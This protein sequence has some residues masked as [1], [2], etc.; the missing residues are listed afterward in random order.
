MIDFQKRN[1][2]LEQENKELREEIAGLRNT[3]LKSTSNYEDQL[4][5]GKRY[6]ESQV[7]FRTIFEQSKLGNK[8]ISPDLKIRKVNKALEEMLGYSEEELIHKKILDFAHP[9]S[10][11]NWLELQKKLWR[12]EMPSFHIEANMLR[13]DGT[14]IWCSVTT[15]LFEDN[16]SKLGYTILEDISER[17]ILSTKLANSESMLAQS[18]QAASI[19]SFVAD[20]QTGMVECT[21]GLNQMF[22]FPEGERFIHKD[23]FFRTIDA[24]TLEKH[25]QILARA[26]E[27][28]GSYTSE[29]KIKVAGLEKWVWE[30]GQVRKDDSGDVTIVG[31]VQANNS[32][33]L[34]LLHKIINGSTNTVTVGQAVRNEMGNIVDFRYI[35]F[36]N[37]AKRYMGAPEDSDE[38]IGKTLTELFPA[39]RHNGNLER[40]IETLENNRS[41]KGLEYLYPHE[42]LNHWFSESAYCFGECIV[43]SLDDITDRK[44][45]EEALKKLAVRNDELDSFVYT[46]SHDLRSPATNIEML[47]EYFFK[48]SQVS[49]EN[50]KS[51]LY[52]NL[53]NQSLTTLKNTLEDLTTVTEI[54]PGEKKELVNLKTVVADVEIM[55]AN[56]IQEAAA[57]VIVDLSVPFLNIPSKHARSLIFNMLSN[58]LKFRSNDRELIITIS[59]QLKNDRIQLSFSDNG[60]GIK[61]A[62]QPKV[63]MIFK[64]FN[65]EVA[66]RGVGMYL[67][68][69]IID[70]NNGNII[71][72]SK[73]NIGTTFH[74]DFPI[75]NS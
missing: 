25:E 52:K 54:H 7:R 8:I 74:I 66:G 49:Q 72:E 2:E 4:T 41:Y 71:L 65:P 14:T 58:A 46:A 22:G 15:I 36:N 62:D 63:F 24:K 61:A 67:V 42:G 43:I 9:D 75:A 33:S 40:Y 53:L 3:H 48:E 35:L 31:V 29:Y 23:L 30:K 34:V 21:P 70:L 10:A 17:I 47:L 32:E 19:G 11:A 73:E 56:Q 51:H 68:K 12:E 18:Q 13:K 64:R 69:R 38:M 28:S 60:K 27:Q 59:S 37:T 6:E 5:T 50:S 57:Q 45:K 1:A 20:F 26:I 16:E 55:L 39:T 44:N